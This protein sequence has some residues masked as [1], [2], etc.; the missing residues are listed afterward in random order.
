MT[1]ISVIDAMKEVVSTILCFIAP[2]TE[3]I[4]TKMIH[5]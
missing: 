5:K 4:V 2:I 1:L 3:G